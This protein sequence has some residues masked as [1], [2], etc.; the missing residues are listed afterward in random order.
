MNYCSIEDV[1]LALV[2]DGTED[3]TNTASDM[4]DQTIDDSI[5]E[6]TSQVDIYIGGPYRLDLG[7]QVP[8]SVRYLTR[9]VAA[10]LATC[11]WRK[12]K[13]FTAMDPVY[14]RWQWAIQ[15]LNSISSGAAE[16]PGGT[17]PSSS[18]AGATVVNIYPFN[19][20]HPWQF[21]LIGRGAYGADF[22]GGSWYGGW[23]HFQ[24]T[25]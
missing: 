7:D 23:W 1:R 6:A 17:G 10:F 18:N 15:Q 20:F 16:I 2:E 13:D 5:A 9:D 21:D 4:D 25:Y 3:G 11:T 19:L 22:G 24:P 12:S 8:D 14:L